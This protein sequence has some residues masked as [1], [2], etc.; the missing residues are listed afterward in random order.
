MRP[1]PSM[2]SGAAAPLTMAYGGPKHHERQHLIDH[3]A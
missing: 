2:V 3:P 1:L